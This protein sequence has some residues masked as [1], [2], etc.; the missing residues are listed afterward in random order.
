MLGNCSTVFDESGSQGPTRYGGL[1]HPQ[2]RP[3]CCFGLVPWYLALDGLRG[4]GLQDGAIFVV[5]MNHIEPPDRHGRSGKMDVLVG[6]L[7]LL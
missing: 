7:N 1:S 2:S 5:E 4:R 6:I 3:A